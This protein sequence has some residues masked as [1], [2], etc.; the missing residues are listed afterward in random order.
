MTASNKEVGLSRFNNKS[1]MSS[2]NFNQNALINVLLFQLTSFVRSW[3][4]TGY[5]EAMYV[6][7]LLLIFKL[8][9]NHQRYC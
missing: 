6:E 4:F 8:D 2:C 3:K 9:W 5:T 7:A 1:F